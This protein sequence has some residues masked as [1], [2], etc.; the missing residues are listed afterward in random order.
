[1][2]LRGRGPRLD[3]RYHLEHL[4]DTLVECRGFVSETSRVIEKK[5]GYKLGPNTIMTIL[6]HEGALEWLKEL[7]VEL[8]ESCMRKSF[9]KA[10]I[11]GDNQ[12]LMWAIS[13]YGHHVDFLEPAKD[14]KEKEIPGYI[15]EF[16]DYMKGKAD[17]PDQEIDAE[18]LALIE[19]L[20]ARADTGPKP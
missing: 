20:K 11:E 8:A 15:A 12:C 3:P 16:C 10:I 17:A 6:R 13:K 2:G 5:Y 9:H 1:M 19:E 18:T 7:R 4:L 14:D